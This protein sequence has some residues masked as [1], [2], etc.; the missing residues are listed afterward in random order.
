MDMIAI[1]P[2]TVKVPTHMR[3][4]S[5]VPQ[6]VTRGERERLI[7]SAA[8]QQTAMTDDNSV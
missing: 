8:N 6:P 2:K 3:L 4:Y 5:S 1:A 7:E